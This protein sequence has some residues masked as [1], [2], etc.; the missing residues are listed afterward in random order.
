MSFK[1]RITSLFLICLMIFATSVSVSAAEK[2][3]T[4]R[5]CELTVVFKDKGRS[6]AGEELSA[7][8]IADISNKG[9]FTVDT[10]YSRYISDP[11]SVFGKGI[12]IRTVA[13]TLEGIIAAGHIQP[14]AKAVTDENGRAHFE[15][16]PVGSYL[17]TGKV[18]NEGTL[19]LYPSSFIINLPEVDFDGSYKYSVESDLKYDRYIVDAYSEIVVNVAKV[20]SDSARNNHDDDSVEIE[21]Y[22]DGVLYTTLTLN[23]GN[24]WKARLD[25]LDIN[26]KWTVFEANGPDGYVAQVD[27]DNNSF[28]VRNTPNQGIPPRDDETTTPGDT[29]TGPNTN[30]NTNTKKGKLPQTGLLWWPV[31]LMVFA[32]AIM[33][34]IG[35]SVKI[36]RRKNEK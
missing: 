19:Y 29:T 18:Y 21:V 32:G 1:K 9:G 15:N 17:I 5:L 4:G 22:G 31:P 10:K 11:Q 14:D 23:K 36:R 6:I 16:M 25:G 13:T 20:W 27:F 30:T 33:I 24:N 34:I 2:I 3:D 7:Y 28:V 35:L 12:G 26:V 8:K